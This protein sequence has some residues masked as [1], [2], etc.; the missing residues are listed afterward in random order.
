MD[1]PGRVRL[2]ADLFNSKTQRGD[3]MPGF[4]QRGPMNEGPMTGRGL[5]RCA[6]PSQGASGT[7]DASWNAPGYGCGGGRAMGR[8]RCR[9][10]WQGVDP[11]GDTKVSR[12]LQPDRNEAL[13]LKVR[14]LESEL[15][16]IK[17]QLKQLENQ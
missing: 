5:G 1:E 7:S 11:L 14:R 4:N 12:L 3:G 15:D 16:A 2:F 6:A 9:R 10:T 13:T 17:N 8:G